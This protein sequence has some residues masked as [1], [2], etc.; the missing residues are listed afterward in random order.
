MT[1]RKQVEDTTDLIARRLEEARHNPELAGMTILPL[2]VLAVDGPDYTI[3]AGAMA[4]DVDDALDAD[5]V[6]LD[7]VA[8]PI[9]TG[10]TRTAEAEPGVDMSHPDDHG[11]VRRLP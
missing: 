1:D 10:M 11:I 6:E 8:T 3:P 4:R 9:G 2:E 5:A 7:D